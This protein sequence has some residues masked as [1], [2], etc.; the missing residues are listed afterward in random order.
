MI[1]IKATTIVAVRRNGKCAIAGDGQ[2]TLGST[3][4]KSTANK[5]RKLNEGNVLAGFAGSVTD[6]FILFDIFSQQLEKYKGNLR[7]AILEFGKEWRNDKFLR[8]LEAMLIVVDKDSLFVLSGNGDII[9]PDEDIIAIGSGGMFA[10]SAGKALLE[11]TELEAKEIVTK[12]L[13]I[14]SSICIYTNKNIV[15]ET[16]G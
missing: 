16:V 15:V 3:V 12:A 10:L 9:E 7:R 6:A 5:I 14:A 11:N 2:V 13:E 1:E 4:M 8:R